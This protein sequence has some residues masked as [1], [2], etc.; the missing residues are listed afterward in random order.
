MTINP[1]HHRRTIPKD[2]IETIGQFQ[3]GELRLAGL[4]D[5]LWAQIHDLPQEP[6]VDLEKLEDVW[7]DIEIIYAQASAAEQT[8]LAPTQRTAVER[9]IE[10][11]TEILR[12]A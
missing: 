5:R 6:S 4:L 7:T 11:M 12:R 2:V 9:A 1:R 10:R 8:T 3:N